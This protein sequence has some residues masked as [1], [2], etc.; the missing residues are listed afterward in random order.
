MGYNLTLKNRFDRNMRKSFI[1]NAACIKNKTF[2]IEVMRVLPI[3]QN[4][5]LWLLSNGQSVGTTVQGPLRMIDFFSS[6]CWS[7][8]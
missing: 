8:L 5:L 1:F 6:L 3:L 2:S 4:D 7:S